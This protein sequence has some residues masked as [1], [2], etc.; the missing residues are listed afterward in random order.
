MKA[1]E[2]CVMISL[3]FSAEIG[4]ETAFAKNSVIQELQDPTKPAKSQLGLN[5]NE[6][7]NRTMS[8]SAIF[9][10][11]NG[12]HAIINGETCIVGQTISGFEVLEIS[13]DKVELRGPEG[14]ETLFFNNISIKKDA[15]NGF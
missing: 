5:D 3:L 13:A 2:M 10:S 7:H 14:T 8:L 1:H 4:A 9:I 12:K 15:Y 11:E 6:Q